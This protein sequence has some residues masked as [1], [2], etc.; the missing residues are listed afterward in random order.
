M[1]KRFLS[2]VEQTIAPDGFRFLSRSCSLGEAG[3]LDEFIPMLYLS[4][5]E[6]ETY[7]GSD[8][9]ARYLTDRIRLSIRDSRLLYSELTLTNARS[10]FADSNRVD[11]KYKYRLREKY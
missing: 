9:F 3:Q 10:R 5:F 2:R 7:R 8:T 11:M 4:F 1:S 6:Q